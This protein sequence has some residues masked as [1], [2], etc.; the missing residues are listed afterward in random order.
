MLKILLCCLIGVSL[1]AP[2]IS[3]KK[4]FVTVH[5]GNNIM[6]VLPMKDVFYYPGFTLGKVFLKDG[7]STVTQL[8]YNRL[9]DEIHFIDG[10][11]DTLAVDNEKNIKYVIAASDTF[12]YDE[13][14]LRII[15]PGKN[16]KLAMRDVWVISETRQRGAYN[17][18]N[19]GV[20]MLAFKSVEQGGR[21]YDLTVNEDVILKKTEKLYFGDDF[22]HFV[23]ANKTNLISLFPK[24]EQR[25]ATFLKENKINFNKRADVE[26][27]TRF[28]QAIVTN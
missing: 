3:Q 6:D 8:N 7:N 11:G 24:D 1:T 21:L 18:T 25:I 27:T 22:N 5:A 15:L 2:V 12:F 4:T 16:V 20:S 10:K 26:K 19:T 17:S 28:V 9:V 14:F 13:G 23:L